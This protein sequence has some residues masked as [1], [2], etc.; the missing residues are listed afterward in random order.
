[1]LHVYPTGAELSWHKDGALGGGAYS[2]YI[3][4]E[5]KHT[6]GGNLMVA[7]PRNQSRTGLWKELNG[8]YDR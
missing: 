6:W 2:F 8:R 1:M 7:D 3:H 4:D 5:W